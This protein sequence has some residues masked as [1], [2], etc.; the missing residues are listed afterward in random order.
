[1]GLVDLKRKNGYSHTSEK[2]HGGMTYEQWRDNIFADNEVSFLARFSTM[3]ATPS[4]QSQDKKFFMLGSI[5]MHGLCAIDLS[6]KPAGHRNVFARDEAEALSYGAPKSDV[7][8]YFSQCQQCSGLENLFGFCSNINQ[9]SESVVRGRKF[10]PGTQQCG[11]RFRLYGYRFVSGSVPLGAIP[12]NKGRGKTTYPFGSAW[13]YS[14]DGYYYARQYSRCDDLGR[15]GSGIVGNLHN[16]SRLFGLWA[17]LCDSQNTGIFCD[18]SEEEHQVQ[19]DLFPANE[20]IERRKGGSDW[21]VKRAL[22]K[23]TLPGKDSADCLHRLDDQQ[24]AGLPDQQHESFSKGNCQPL[25]ITLASRTVFQ[26][27]Q[28]TFEDQSVLRD[29]GKRGQNPNLDC[30]FDLRPNCH[31]QKETQAKI[32]NLFDTANHECCV[33]RKD[34]DPNSINRCKLFGRS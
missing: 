8:K 25:Q 15:I 27:D 30:D 14:N 11:L 9:E 13:Q 19:K 17:S 4:W 1:M 28:I 10:W 33:I 22:F 3:R 34:A 7:A 29:F 24:M 20:K 6:R 2:D 18:P 12:Q 32:I 26:M 31:N 16:G 5:F 23:A 21:H